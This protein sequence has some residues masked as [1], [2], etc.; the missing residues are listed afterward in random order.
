MKSSLKWRVGALVFLSLAV[1]L[2]VLL[3][4][5][6]LPMFS[7]RR[8]EVDFGYA[9]PI[10]P[11][12]AVRVSGVVVGAVERVEWVG[13]QDE[14]APDVMVRLHARIQDRAWP[15]ITKRSRFYVTTLGVL[16]EHYLEVVPA[17][18][19]EPLAE[20]ARVRGTDLPRADLLLP[21]AA[22]LLE[23][24]SAVLDEGRDEAVALLQAIARLVER[25]DGVLAEDALVA[26]A[27]ALLKDAQSVLL[28]LET[29]IG[30]GTA[31]KGALADIRGLA[32][33]ADRVLAELERSDLPATLGQARS[34]LGKAD[35][36]LDKALK[37]PLADEEQQRRLLAS[38]EQTF[39]S[40]DQ[41]ARRADR[42]LAKVERGEGGAGLAFHDEALVKDLKAV[43]GRL[44]ENPLGLFFG[45]EK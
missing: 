31:L 34:A 33:R 23:E 11:G 24:M 2:A 39:R 7:G 41:V 18:K 9:G 22:A 28:G 26:K 19:G 38:F 25:L 44:R 32:A 6:P 1:L 29:A 37:S 42:L 35:R 13:G 15:A 30:D 43:L 16:G 12:A 20:G 8:L 3:M 21:R 4:T 40:L 45:R 27:T 10:K 17:P 14:A 5:G 36:V